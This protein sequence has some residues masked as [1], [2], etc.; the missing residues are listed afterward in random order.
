VLWAPVNLLVSLAVK[1]GASPV[2]I[3]A[4]R[5][6]SL[7]LLLG[8]CLTVPS[9][10]RFT[11]ARW[12][13]T[14]DRIIAIALGFCFFGPAHAIYYYAITRTSTFE[15]NILGTTAPLWVAVLSFFFLRER[16]SRIRV[17]AIVV[18]FV[19]AYVVSVGFAAPSLN[20]GHTFGNSLYLGAVVIE[21]ICGVLAIQIARRSSG[22]TTLWLQVVGAAI[23]LS[24]APIVLPS[25]F[26][27]T[28][29]GSGA[30][31]AFV[32]TYLVLI[33]GLVTFGIWYTLAEKAPL[34]LMVIT[35]LLQPPLATGLGM[36]F[37]NEKPNLQT[38]LGSA[39]ILAALLIGT[40]EKGS[41]PVRAE[42]VSDGEPDQGNR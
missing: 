1:D 42:R 27:Y 35:L 36:L 4:T 16:I 39:L 25:V 17:I 12:P 26:P 40:L 11:N 7:A 14:K 29:N 24:A 10:R 19:G 30:T 22:I 18:G 15:G 20:Q 28:F 8:L 41:A 23:F 3:A 21:S 13:I 5:W 38:A 32:L 33:S 34:S 37:L 9:F 31:T 2:A 6:C